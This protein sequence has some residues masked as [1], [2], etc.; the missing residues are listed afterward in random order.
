MLAGREFV[1]R[2]RLPL[3]TT[4]DDLTTYRVIWQNTTATGDFT[5]YSET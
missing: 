4:A 1:V 5:L 3:N 2:P